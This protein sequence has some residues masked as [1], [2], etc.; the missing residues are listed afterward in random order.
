M[1]TTYVNLTLILIPILLFK[2][3]KT[4]TKLQIAKYTCRKLCTGY[5]FFF[6]FV[7]NYF[8][9]IRFYLSLKSFFGLILQAKFNLLFIV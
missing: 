6:C 4:N 8:A 7:I 3:Q 9:V 2:I 5:D 1:L